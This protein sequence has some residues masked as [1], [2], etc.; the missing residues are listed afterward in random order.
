MKTKTPKFKKKGT[1]ETLNSNIT[2]I[3]TPEPSERAIGTDSTTNE[4][5]NMTSG[6]IRKSIA[7][8]EG[9]DGKIIWERM[10]GS[11]KDALREFIVRPEVWDGLKI[12]K[13]GDQP[14]QEIPSRDILNSDVLSRAYDFIGKFE[15]FL[16]KRVTGCSD[17][18]AEKVF[19]FDEEEKS[20]LVP[21]TVKLINKY[22]PNWM[23]A[24]NEEIEFCIVILSIH[25][26]KIFMLRVLLERDRR[27]QLTNVPKPTPISQ[28]IVVPERMEPEEPELQ[29]G[30]DKKTDEGKQDSGTMPVSVESLE[31]QEASEPQPA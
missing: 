22:G 24:Y 10:R 21:A 9:S 28:P 2:S 7:W 26:N 18:I 17:E 8:Y 29:V 12:Q 15:A 27:A 20:A 11:S 14:G 30:A 25:M 5:T 13:P 23:S 4:K 31:H 19:I 16:A 6:E 3:S 1:S